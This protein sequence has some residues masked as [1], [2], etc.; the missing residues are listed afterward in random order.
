MQKRG[1][2]SPEDG[3]ALAL[4]FVQPVAPRRRR[5]KSATKTTSSVGTAG[6]TARARGCDEPHSKRLT[7]T[8]H[9]ADLAARRQRLHGGNTPGLAIAAKGRTQRPLLVIPKGAGNA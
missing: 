1:Q 9:L 7:K 3:D 2:A 8:R 4:T 6:S 5:K